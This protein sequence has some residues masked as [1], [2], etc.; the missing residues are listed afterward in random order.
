[1]R[2]HKHH[3]VRRGFH[4]KALGRQ[5][6]TG[7]SSRP[8]DEVPSWKERSLWKAPDLCVSFLAYPNC[9]MLGRLMSPGP[10][11][12]FIKEVPGTTPDTYKVKH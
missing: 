12:S 2:T 5:G 11:P 10:C 3:V 8:P 7:S 6:V 1:M 9:T 4:S